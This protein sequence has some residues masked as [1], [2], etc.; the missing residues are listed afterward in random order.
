MHPL[1]SLERLAEVS[2]M[3]ASAPRKRMLVVVNPY[4]TT[5]SDRLKNLV[6]YALQGRYDVEAID[7][8]ARNHATALGRE[9]AQEGYDAVW[10]TPLLQLPEVVSA[11]SAHAGR[12]LL[13]GGSEDPAWNLRAATETGG[14]AVQIDGGDHA[15][16]ATDAVRT[17]ELHVEVTRAIDRWLAALVAT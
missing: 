2:A 8:K 4:A 12:Q 7:T 9:A 17:A 10:L 11:L 3:P 15:M 16:F 1:E 6:V 5:V 13:I 14:D